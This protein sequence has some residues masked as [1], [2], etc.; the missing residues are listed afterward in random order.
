MK[1]DRRYIQDE[2]KFLQYSRA[3]LGQCFVSHS[4]FDRFYSL[5]PDDESKNIFLRV[6]SFYLFLVQ[7]G[8]WVNEVNNKCAV[9]DY[10]TNSYKLVGV[11]SL[12]E[13]LGER[14]HQDF[15]RWL[16][17]QGKAN[18][19][20][21]IESPSVLESLFTNYIHV[22]GATNHCVAFFE[23]LPAEGQ[24]ELMRAIQIRGK[25]VSTVKRAVQVLYGL[26]SRFVHE[27]ELLTQL[28]DRPIMSS[29][30]G[31]VHLFNLSFL[32]FAEL[33]EQAL[34]MH[35]AVKHNITLQRTSKSVA[36]VV[37]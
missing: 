19:A 6:A 7:K 20:F 30:N 21:P 4:E 9:T 35:F 1:H 16:C 26:R 12:I 14:N 17:S 24:A 29:L 27:A 8:D 18:G 3:A 34:I 22:H 25:A 2:Q 15:Y 36:F 5:L 10:L 32:K 31:K 37:H 13:S 33:F 11:F 28:Y 23:R